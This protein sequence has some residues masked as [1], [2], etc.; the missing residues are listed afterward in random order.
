MALTE[1]RV[2]THDNF[3][4]LFFAQAQRL[5]DRV[6]MRQKEFGIWRRISWNDYAR[7]VRW[8]AHALLALGLERGDRVAI[9]GENRP[10]WLYADVGAQAA[11][12]VVVGIYATSSPEQVQYIMAHSESRFI[13]VEGEEQLDKLLELRA[14]LP[15]LERIIVMDPEGLRTFADPQVSMFGEFL[16]IGEQHARAHPQAVD[17]RLAAAAPDDVMYLIYT[18]GTTGAP[19]GVMLTSRNILW[20]LR[21]AVPDV[22]PAAAHDEVL[23]YLPL[24]HI[25]ERSFSLTIAVYCGYTVNFAESLDT[26]PQN[27]REVRPTLVF[28]VPRIW[29]KLHSGVILSMRDADWVKRVVFALAVRVG[30]AYGDAVLAGR[31]VPWW[32]RAAYRAAHVMVLAPLRNRIGLDRTHIA[33]SA[34]APISP[35]VLRFFWGL[36]VQIR[37]IYGQTEGS[38]LTTAHPVGDVRLGT[39][40]KPLPGI[41]VQLASDGEILVRSPGVF[42]GYFR[43]SEQTSSTIVDGWLHSG[44][45]GEFDAGGNL[46]ITDRKKDIFINAYGKNVAPQYI[47]NKLKFSPFINDAVVIGDGKKYLA[48][49]IVIDEDNVTKWAQERRAPFTTFTDLSQSP[50]VRKLITAEVEAVNKTLS[51]PEQVKK[52]ALLP[53]RLYQEDG[54]VTPTMKVKRK[55]IMEKFADTIAELYRD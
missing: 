55:A 44:D 18:S 17:D 42:S 4:A 54:E 7:N 46:R 43:D 15:H 25:A 6:A 5:A 41:D 9:I 20:E 21:S 26:V 49:L 30:R 39:V 40:G 8:V 29:E 13:I 45:I 12:G 24:A 19:K 3:P 10:E 47:E 48:A 11:G 53:K 34:A 14:A 1:P 27:L 32:L 52:F 36:G 35:D 50:S 33:L 28:A 2:A 16:R 38:G 23:S 22:I 31:P 37:E 51:S